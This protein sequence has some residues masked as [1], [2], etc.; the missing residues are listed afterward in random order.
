VNKFYF[1]CFFLFAVSAL[2]FHAWAGADARLQVVIDPGHGGND[3]GS[4]E[5]VEV[6]KNWNLKFAQ[7]LDKALETAGYQVLM[8][9]T[10]DEAIEPENRLNMINSSNAKLVLVIHADREWT[11]TQ[12]GPFLVVEPPN[13]SAAAVVLDTIRPLGV[14]TPAQFHS[15]L[16]LAQAIGQKL[17]VNTSLSDLSDSRGIAGE[18]VSPN[19]KV[20]CLPHQDLRYLSKPAVVLTPLFLTSASDLKKFADSDALDD[21]ALKVVQGVNDYCQIVTKPAVM[22]Q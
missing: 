4:K 21:F 20:A 14:I 11:H 8:T 17:G 3:A 10:S 22:P 7:V 9:R 12:T 18:T 16:K 13:E 19:G 2:G 6:E 1:I 15:S 5:G